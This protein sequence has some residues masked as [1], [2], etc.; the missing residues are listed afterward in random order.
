MARKT[1]QLMAVLLC[2]TVFVS[3]FGC[4]KKRNKKGTEDPKAKEFIES[5]P[6]SGKLIEESD[7][8]YTLSEFDIELPE[9]NERKVVSRFFGDVKILES[10]LFTLIEEE[11]EIDEALNEKWIAHITGE[12]PLSDEEAEQIEAMVSER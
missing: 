3:S 11:Y 2:L 10:G 7:P 12:H 1:K 5:L 4:G 9:K 8:F 6:E